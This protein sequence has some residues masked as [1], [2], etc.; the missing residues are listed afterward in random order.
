MALEK[1]QSKDVPSN[2]DVPSSVDFN[3]SILNDMNNMSM[4]SFNLETASS[5]G[6]GEMGQ[7]IFNE[8][9]DGVNLMQIKDQLMARENKINQ[10]VGD[11]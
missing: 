7:S 9:I 4:V 8:G 6:L 11:K 10:L 5:M 2:S 1:Q 3:C